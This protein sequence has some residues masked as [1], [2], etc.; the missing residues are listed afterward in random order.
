MISCILSRRSRFRNNWERNSLTS[1][2]RIDGAE[3]IDSQLTIKNIY[4]LNPVDNNKEWSI[5]FQLPYLFLQ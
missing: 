1:F 5:I 4:S 3:V 2:S